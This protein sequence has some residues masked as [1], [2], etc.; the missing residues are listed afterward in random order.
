MRSRFRGPGS[1]GPAPACLW[2]KGIVY[3]DKRGPAPAYS[4]TV[5]FKRGVPAGEP[6]RD[7]RAIYD[8]VSSL[9]HERVS[10]LCGPTSARSIVCHGWH[11]L[12]DAGSIAV[13]FVTL[14]TGTP[15]GVRPPSGEELLAPGGTSLED[16]VRLSPQRVSECFNEF[17]LSDPADG[18]PVTVSFA[19]PVP[20]GQTVDFEPILDRAGEFARRYH[21]ALA[22]MGEVR[23]PFHVRH[24][25]WF[26]AD[27]ALVTVH[28]CFDC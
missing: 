17:D 20:S 26:L 23:S 15:D 6:F 1:D 16:L 19:E 14:T 7:F 22:L 12:G 21:A 18:C 27:P 9:A 2:R 5:G 11:L 25:E 10:E 8:R 28:I 13:A 24:R 4:I 3:L